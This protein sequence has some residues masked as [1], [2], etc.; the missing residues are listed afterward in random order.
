MSK[1]EENYS[2]LTK[3]LSAILAALQD[4][5]LPIE[6]AVKKHAQGQKIIERLEKYLQSAENTI[7]KVTDT[8]A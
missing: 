4:N 6:E 5:D 8:A 2:E 3:E 1:Q 7:T